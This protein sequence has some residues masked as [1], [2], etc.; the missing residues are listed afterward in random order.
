MSYQI[1]HETLSE[2]LREH[3]RNVHS[4]IGTFMEDFTEMY[5]GISPVPYGQT[6]QDHRE[7]SFLKAKRTKK[8]AH[9]SIYRMDC[10]RYELTS[11]IA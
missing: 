1:Y 2:A 10:G 9:A 5:A 3:I 11:Y 6:L 4:Q 8:W 7:L